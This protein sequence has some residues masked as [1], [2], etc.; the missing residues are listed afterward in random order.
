MDFT[1]RNLAEEYLDEA[2]AI[3][4]EAD[5]QRDLDEPEK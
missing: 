3:G 4:E 2:L 1:F 5:L